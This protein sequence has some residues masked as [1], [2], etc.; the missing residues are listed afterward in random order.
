MQPI[1]KMNGIVLKNSKIDEPY[2]KILIQQRAIIL[3]AAE[4]AAAVA[5]A[6]GQK[7]KGR[8]SSS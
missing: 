5:A 6:S 2:I 8:P 7:K 1:E 4:A 3:S